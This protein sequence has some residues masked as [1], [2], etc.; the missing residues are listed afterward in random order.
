MFREDEYETCERCN[1]REGEASC[2]VGGVE[3]WL[4]STC[5]A[6]LDGLVNPLFP[7]AEVILV[8]PN[9]WNK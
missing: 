6:T 3:E 5:I 7:D 4:C 1:A 2:G 9:D 8:D